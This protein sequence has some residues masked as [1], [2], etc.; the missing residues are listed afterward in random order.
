MV[1]WIDLLNCCYRRVQALANQINNRQLEAKA[2]QMTYLRLWVVANGLG[3]MLSLLLIFVLGFV[4]PSGSGLSTTGWGL[5][6]ALGGMQALI[7]RRRLPQLKIWHWM[8][9]TGLGT[10]VGSVLSAF[11]MLLFIATGHEVLSIALKLFPSFAESMP[12]TLMQTIFYVGHGISIGISVG[13]AQ[14][15]VLRQHTPNLRLWWTM[16]VLGHTLGGT[17]AFYGVWST[18][19][20]FLDISW[21]SMVLVMRGLCFGAVGG[22]IYGSITAIAFKSLR[23]RQHNL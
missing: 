12:S 10:Y 13:I 6:L 11:G 1:L 22:V 17:I 19:G 8:V 7:L 5:G 21:D 9:A 4:R 18:A 3:F 23:P 2:M 15:L 14:V 16:G 20:S